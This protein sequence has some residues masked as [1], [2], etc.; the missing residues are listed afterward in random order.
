MHGLP[1][2]CLPQT[3]ELEHAQ[4]TWNGPWESLA[5]PGVVV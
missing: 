4:Q 1:F 5:G 2:S 3:H